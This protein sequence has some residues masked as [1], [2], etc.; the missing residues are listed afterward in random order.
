LAGASSPV[1]HPNVS[2][3]GPTTSS[4]VQV[5]PRKF[6]FGSFTENF[7]ANRVRNSTLPAMCSNHANSTANEQEKSFKLRWFAEAVFIFQNIRW[8][9]DQS[10]GAE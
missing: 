4:A 2:A 7:P 1:I 8:Q 6:S 5:N 10:S 9:P 3:E